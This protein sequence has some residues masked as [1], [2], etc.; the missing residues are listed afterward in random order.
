MASASVVQ[1]HSRRPHAQKPEHQRARVSHQPM[2]SSRG[3]AALL[4]SLYAQKCSNEAEVPA[5]RSTACGSR[6]AGAHS[7]TRLPFMRCR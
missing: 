4:P 3:T 1:M 7:M 5:S 6:A 2:R